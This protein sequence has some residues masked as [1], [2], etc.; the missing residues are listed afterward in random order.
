VCLRRIS[1]DLVVVSS[2]LRFSFA[3]RVAAL[4]R[5]SFVTNFCLSTTTN[6][7]TISFAWL[8]R[9]SGKDDGAPLAHWSACSRR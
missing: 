9:G 1:L 2:D 6:S 8:Q 3:A 4:V 5:W 7:T